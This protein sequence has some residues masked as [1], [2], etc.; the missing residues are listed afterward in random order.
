LQ[1]FKRE[2]VEINSAT[3]NNWIKLGIERLE[4]LYEYQMRHLLNQKY[5]Q[6]DET[7][8]KVLESDKAGACHLGYLWVYNTP[9]GGHTLFKYE[10]GRG[11]KYPQ[12]MMKD[13]SGY[14]Q[15]DGY[16]GYERLSKRDDITHLA[17]WAHVR[18]KFEEALKNDQTLAQTA[19]T[20]IQGLYQVE[21]EA[22]DLGLSSEERKVLRLDKSL[23]IYNILGKW[24]SHHLG[25]TM[26][27]S[28]IGKA[29]RYAQERWDELGHYMLDGNLEI[30]NNKIENA[31]RPI[32]I[33]R[34]NYLFAGNHEAAQR[35]A[36]VYTFMSQCKQ[37]Q[38]NP[39]HWLKYVL[40]NILD[41]KTSQLIS[42][43]PAN[44]KNNP[45]FQD[46]VA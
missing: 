45:L 2:A 5:L 17:C 12:E 32:A 27:K 36:I 39:Y 25:D 10:K 9:L 3:I 1:R 38:V 31:I 26:P 24:I 21:R 40:E 34:K 44:L 33:G 13:F 8:L 30:D 43:T 23:P 11:A 35:A 20:L 28:S 19:M 6:V 46:V 16:G 41:T 42:L 22:K 7:T 37:H 29:M 4:L 15:T 18:R 14:L